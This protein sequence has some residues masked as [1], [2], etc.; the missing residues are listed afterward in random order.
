MHYLKNGLRAMH[1]E[2]MPEIMEVYVTP[3]YR[4]NCI[5]MRQ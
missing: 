5:D 1:N 2:N 3:M 4:K